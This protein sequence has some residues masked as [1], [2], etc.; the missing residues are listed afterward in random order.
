MK[1]CNL[2]DGS[3]INQYLLK[4]KYNALIVIIDCFYPANFGSLYTTKY[5][6]F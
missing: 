2:K 5:T 1:Y 4:S 6:V 3:V